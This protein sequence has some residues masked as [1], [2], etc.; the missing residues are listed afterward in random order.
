MIK[1]PWLAKK[2]I[3]EA[4]E[5]RLDATIDKTENLARVVE[6]NRM[7][8]TFEL[9]MEKAHKEVVAIVANQE[10]LYGADVFEACVIRGKAE[11]KAKLSTS[12]L[13]NMEKFWDTFKV[14]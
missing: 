4:M 14:L 13:E 6:I 1:K 12:H 8:K 5:L 9:L 11:Y 10:Y 7:M 3:L 2:K